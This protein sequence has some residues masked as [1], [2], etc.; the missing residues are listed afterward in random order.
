LTANSRKDEYAAG[1]VPEPQATTTQGISVGKILSKTKGPLLFFALASVVDLLSTWLCWT[2]LKS[3]EGHEENFIVVA[4]V[5]WFGLPAGLV[6]CKVAAALV[7]LASSVTLARMFPKQVTDYR[8]AE[9]LFVAMG[10][11][12][13][14]AGFWNVCGLSL[15][16]H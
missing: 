13:L 12:Y 16:Q 7:V 9:M 6:G 3:R 5:R 11:L 10:C 14:A 2:T 8:L 1:A 4:F 15:S